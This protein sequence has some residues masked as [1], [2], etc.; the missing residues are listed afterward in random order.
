MI[1]WWALGSIFWLGFIYFIAAIPA[2]KALGWPT[3]GAAGV[4]LLGYSAG[5]IAVLLLGEPLRRWWEQRKKKRVQAAP[6]D[7]LPLW[8]R[9]WNRGGIWMLGIVAPVTLGPQISALVA[10]SLG[11]KPLRIWLALSLGAIPW[12]VIFSLLTELGGHWW[13]KI[14][15]LFS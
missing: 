4:A 8:Q 7:R 1:T 6:T 15:G 13:E 14:G 9:A 12:A 5:A 11:E 10:L 2:G 3:W